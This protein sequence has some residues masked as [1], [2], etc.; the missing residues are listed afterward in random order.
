MIKVK[1][2]GGAKKIFGFESM[3]IDNCSTYFT[4]ELPLQEL[5]DIFSRAVKPKGSD[6]I[7]PKNTHTC[8]I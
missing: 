8:C 3:D 6:G 7:D 2:L 4:M 5:L 1:M